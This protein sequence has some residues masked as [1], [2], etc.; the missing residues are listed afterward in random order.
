MRHAS[1]LHDN[2]HLAFMKIQSMSA[3][4][5]QNI[6]QMHC[7]NEHN[8]MPRD[9]EHHGFNIGHDTVI[10]YYPDQK[11]YNAVS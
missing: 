9:I 1:A 6:Q 10:N 11:I 8:I 3:N 7:S 5:H 4:A 2:T